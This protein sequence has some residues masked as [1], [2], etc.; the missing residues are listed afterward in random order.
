MRKNKS[1]KKWKNNLSDQASVRKYI[2]VNTYVA[3]YKCEDDLIRK[4]LNSARKMHHN[5]RESDDDL[6]RDYF[7]WCVDWI[8]FDKLW[9]ET[10][11]KV[12][13]LYDAVN[14]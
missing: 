7:T 9:L 11:Q 5:A 14:S 1:L 13:S 6:W 12:S 3:P 10:Q 8:T 4:I 2:L